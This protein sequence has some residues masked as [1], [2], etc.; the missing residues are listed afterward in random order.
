MPGGRPL[1][2]ETVE[3]M[4][5]LIDAYFAETEMEEWTI[6]GLALAL[7]TYRQ[8]LINYEGKPEFMDAIKKAKTKVEH[9]YEISLRKSGRSG[10]IFGLK[11]FGWKDKQE[12]EHTGNLQVTAVEHTIVED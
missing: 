10:D 6:T 12:R 4:Q 7:D 3:I 5:E 9:A 1:K 11:N 2:F 8:T